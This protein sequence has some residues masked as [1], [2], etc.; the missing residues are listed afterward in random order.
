MH[1]VASDSHGRVVGT[2]ALST[3]PQTIG[4][5]A[6]CA[7]VLPGDGVSRV[8]AS[9]YL[10]QGQVVLADQGSANGV[11]VDGASITAPTGV[12]ERSTIQIS[13][14][15]LT[16]RH[17]QQHVQ[18]R[19][20]PPE[21]DDSDGLGNIT[22]LEA[23]PL[24]PPQNR[25]ALVLVGRGGPYDNTR[26]PVER[27][28]SMVG[29]DDDNEVVLN[30]PSISRR[31]AQL[32]IC[33]DGRRLTVLDLRSSNGTFVDGERIKR[34][35]MSIGSIV[36]FG[37]LA[38]KLTGVKG[39]VTETREH[40]SSRRRR[41]VVIAL[42]AATVLF[43]VGGIVAYILR[44]PPEVKRPLTAEELLRSQQ[45]A[46]L[47]SLD[48]ARRKLA[49]RRWSEAVA[50]LDKIS[51]KDP[52][53]PEPKQLRSHAV[54]ELGNQRTFDEGLRHF[55]LGD[56]QSLGK[57]R[58]L[59]QSVPASSAYGR[60]A[61]YKL[62]A[63][64]RRQAE[65]FR[66][67]GVS[68]C[69]AGYHRECYELLCKYFAL[70]PLDAR[71]PGEPGLRRRMARAESRIKHSKRFTVCTAERY[72]HRSVAAAGGPSASERIAERYKEPSL[73]RLVGLYQGG[74]VDLAL[75]QLAR[76]RGKRAMRPHLGTLG[77]LR[78]NFLTVRGK[79]QEGY[80]FLRQR[81]V[82]ESDR[83]FGALLA[84][85]ARIL[86]PGVVGFYRRDVTRALARLYGEVGQEKYSVKQLLAAHRL[87]SRGKQLDP[88]NAQVLNGL[89]T[90]EK[91]ADRLLRQGERLAASGKISAART[92]LETARDI[93]TSGGA[94]Q[95]RAEA[96]LAKL[97]GK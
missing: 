82:G 21:V 16:L 35:D 83:E 3:S 40:R 38:F 28:L 90:L 2:V 80:S 36:R 32:R 51:E 54:E 46:L 75:K 92:R 30:D 8:H 13:S 72:L 58:K 85:D 95:K 41:R 71:A 9:I 70:M 24:V 7:L 65:T 77:E 96:L 33:T 79:Y 52:F 43:A 39:G 55:S 10:L 84:A 22:Y 76:L 68:R 59:F 19:S 49:A 97:G 81:S 20:A 67:D 93:A 11:Q 73:Q 42:S 63:I 57:A 29:R 69:V 62:K 4:R 88:S 23:P 1:L 86:P 66:I 12:S 89:L 45:N 14:Y 61:H 94:L 37:D 64:D 25:P 17:E 26:F 87:W 15:R 44:P 18:A 50:L 74:N 31:H 27:A 53:N 91:E 34:A 47:A 78:R 56:D 5:S 48:D 60:D 6:S